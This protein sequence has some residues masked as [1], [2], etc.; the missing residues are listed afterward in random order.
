VGEGV[1][2][3]WVLAIDFGTTNTTAAM[4]S[5]DGSGAVVLEIENSR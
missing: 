2:D 1:S 5:A 4:A 3:G